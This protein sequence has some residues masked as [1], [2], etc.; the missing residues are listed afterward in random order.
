MELTKLSGQ[1]G[2]A[3]PVAATALPTSDMDKDIR[4]PS[5][6]ALLRQLPPKLLQDLGDGKAPKDGKPALADSDLS[7]PDVKLSATARSLSALLAINF[8]A[9]AGPSGLKSGPTNGANNGINNGINNAASSGV[10]E[11]GNSSVNRGSN[12]S[13]NSGMNSGAVIKGGQALLPS[14]AAIGTR[15]TAAALASVI[16]QSGLFYE[17]HLLDLMTGKMTRAALALEPQAKLGAQASVAAT[18]LTG[19]IVSADAAD[20]APRVAATSLPTTAINSPTPA[21]AAPAAVLVPVGLPLVY[22]PAAQLLGGKLSMPNTPAANLNLTNADVGASA[23]DGVGADMPLDDALPD[24]LQRADVGAVSSAAVAVHP[25]ALALV[26]QQL[27]LLAVPQFRWSGEAW[28]GSPMEWEVRQEEPAP[29]EPGDE[30]L[31]PP[32][33]N[34]TTHLV[35]TL[36]SLKVVDVHLSLSGAQLQ[37]RLAASAENTLNLMGRRG[38]ELAER[39]SALGLALSALQISALEA[40]SQQDNPNAG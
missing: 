23:G 21:S 19:L 1:S 5:R 28:P 2:L 13:I 20:A 8:D 35:L 29:R 32:S 36:P 34:W 7:S 33:P 9:D 16:S 3:A 37:L 17:S 40:Q 15:P 39:F 24:R 38:H 10:D 4:G 11:A 12:N 27:E 25:E 6:E 30:S 14:A 18:A 22:G 31:E 26:R